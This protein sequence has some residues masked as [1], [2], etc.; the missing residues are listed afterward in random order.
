MI[1]ELFDYGIHNEAS[2]IRAHVAPLASCV[3]VFPTICGVKAMK[4]KQ[5]KLAYQ[6][7][8]DYPTAEGALVKPCEIAHLRTIRLHPDRF[9]GFTEQL[10]TSEKGDK[11]VEIVQ[12]MLKFGKFPLWLE[13]E[14]VKDVSIQTTGTDVVVKGKWKIEVKCD[15]RASAEKGSPNK[16]CTGNLFLQTAERNPFHYV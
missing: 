10:S 6:P 9:E 16:L 5:K 12:M 1:M 15:F 4:G 7:G 14:F 11:A 3:F 13:G 2:N 8:V